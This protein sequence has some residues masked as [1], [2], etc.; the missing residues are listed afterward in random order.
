[1]SQAKQ[2]PNIP[3]KIFD[4]VG[5]NH[6][7]ITGATFDSASP[8]TNVP[9]SL[10]FTN[11]AHAV[12][13]GDF[14]ACEGLSAATIMGWAMKTDVTTA[15]TLFRKISTST[16]ALGAYFSNVT[17]MKFVVE[18]RNGAAS[19]AV[20]DFSGVITNN[21]WF[22]WAMVFNGGGATDADK[23]KLYVNGTERTLTYTSTIGATTPSNTAT[24]YIGWDTSI[25]SLMGKI[26]D[27]RFYNTNVSG[28]RITDIYNST[29][30]PYIDTT[31]LVAQWQCNDYLNSR[32][33]ML[34]DTGGGVFPAASTLVYQKFEEGSGTS[35]FDESQNVRTGT[36]AKTS[37]GNL[38]TWVSRND[39][40]GN[41][42]LDFDTSGKV[43]CGTGIRPTSSFTFMCVFE[44]D[45]LG[46]VGKYPHLV[47]NGDYV[48]GTDRNG[49][50]LFLSYNNDA[51]FDFIVCN[52]GSSQTTLTVSHATCGVIAGK[53][54]HIAAVFDDTANFIYLYVN[55]VQYG[56]LACSH[57]VGYGASEQYTIGFTSDPSLPNDANYG[58]DGRIW[59]HTCLTGALDATAI[60]N[61]YK[62]TLGIQ[63]ELQ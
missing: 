33:A 47:G 22:H 50:Y 43:Q 31:N 27:F 49:W 20:W 11:S 40:G 21:T 8:F 30:A 59:W 44:A 52:G 12:S 39:G 25:T 9:T 28:T 45:S 53:K 3:S 5:S 15:G 62:K 24:A 35:A 16:S 46:G 58:Y 57:A 6:G 32:P 41:Y 37:T 18:V 14:S 60:M 19:Y 4:Y 48:S 10:S 54:Y 36:L 17:G 61:N 26:K 56:S 13:L 38:P 51:S 7:L 29:S 63:D 42:C 23:L 55:G 1:M 34:V 2:K